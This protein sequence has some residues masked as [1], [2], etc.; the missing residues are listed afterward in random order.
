MGSQ[1]RH[2]GGKVTIVQDNIFQNIAINTSPT[3]VPTANIINTQ[4]GHVS[5]SPITAPQ[6]VLGIINLISKPY[7]RVD[8]FIFTSGRHAT[9]SALRVS[10]KPGRDLR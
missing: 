10:H 4:T 2:S 5:I 3:G 8:V 7:L 9:S 6:I 1:V